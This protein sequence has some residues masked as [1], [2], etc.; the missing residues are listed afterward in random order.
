MANDTITLMLEGEVPLR[1]FAEAIRAFSQLIIALT[2]EE[3]GDIEWTIEDL[4]PG[5][6]LATI[7][8]KSQRPER[9]ERVVRNYAH[10]GKTLQQNQPLHRPP[11]IAR[12]A[13][14]LGRIIGGQI[15]SVRFETAEE[16]A[17]LSSRPVR[18]RGLPAGDDVIALPLDAVESAGSLGAVE[19]EVQTLSKRHGL[20]FTLYDSLND[21]AVSCYLQPGQEEKMREVWGKRAIIEG[22]VSR[23]PSDGHPVAVRRVTEVI[24]LT[25]KGDYTQ[26]RGV[27]SFRETSLLPEERLRRWRDA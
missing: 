15:I 20:R 16:E 24:P 18:K 12:A 14:A 9:V 6:A 7:R 4:Q 11:S 10:V 23:N 22:W 5:S 13:Y 8:G 1:S 17:V 3:G 21:R 26:A 2:E 25:E 19:G 27:L